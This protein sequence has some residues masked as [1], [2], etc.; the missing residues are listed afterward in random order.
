VYFTCVVAVAAG[1]V[2]CAVSGDELFVPGVRVSE[3]RRSFAVASC[4]TVS[5]LPTPALTV[6]S[7]VSLKPTGMNPV[8]QKATVPYVVTAVRW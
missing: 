3:L 8:L 7:T 5:A 1:H 4:D 6:I 2:A